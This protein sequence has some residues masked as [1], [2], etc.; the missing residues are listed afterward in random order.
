VQGT[1]GIRKM[2]QNIENVWRIEML[3]LHYIRWFG[4][5]FCR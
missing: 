5:C 4:E 3:N 1:E 2:E